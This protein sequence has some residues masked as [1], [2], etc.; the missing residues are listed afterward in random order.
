[1]DR[2][3]GEATNTEKEKQHDARPEETGNAIKSEAQKS[4]AEKGG[5]G[6]PEP[7]GRNACEKLNPPLVTLGK[8]SRAE[9]LQSAPD[10]SRS[11]VPPHPI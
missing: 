7:L 4:Q 11:Q 6:T 1:M 5:E 3:R 8:R 10:A 2:N 9:V